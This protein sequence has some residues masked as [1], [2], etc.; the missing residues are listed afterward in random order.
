MTADEVL[1]DLET[2]T[3]KKILEKHKFEIYYSES[4]KSWR[5]YLPDETKPNKRRALKR[6]SR[7]NLEKEIIRFYK[8]KQKASK[9][10]NITLEDLYK[11]WLIYKRDHTATK[12]KTIQEYVS[13]WNKFFNATSLASMPV[14]EITPIII[15]RFFRELTRK[16]EY[17]HKRISNARSVLNGIMSYAI[18]EEIIS[19]NPVSDVNFRNFAYKPV[20]NQSDNV[21]SHEETVQLLYYLENIIEPYSLAIQLAFYL[22][23][24][25]GEMKA[26]KWEDIDYQK[27]IVYLHTQATCERILNDDLTFAKREVAVV[28]Q[29]K[30]YTSH[31]FRKQYLTDEALKILQKAKELNPN[32]IYVFEPHGKIMTTDRFNRKLKKYCEEAGVPYYSSHKIRFY[33]ASTAFD[34]NNLTTIS[35]LMGHSQ[36]ATTLHYLRNVHRHENNMLAFQKLGI[37]S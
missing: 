24:R 21:F 6:T 17:T 22:F 16:R 13:E 14:A 36:V 27:R 25:I 18:E 35:Y 33:N 5:T 32:G 10:T 29:M 37:S 12:A 30:G 9:R 20:E 8:E 34:G 2:M 26:I 28:N 15:I 23:I 3:H 1:K 4:E 11:E 7:E 19:H 31:G